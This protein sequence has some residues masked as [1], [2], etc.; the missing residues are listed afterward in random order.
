MCRAPGA[1]KLHTRKT[2]PARCGC[3]SSR[4]FFPR[5]PLSITRCSCRHRAGPAGFSAA[6]RRLFF[7]PTVHTACRNRHC[8]EP[9]CPSRRSATARSCGLGHASSPP[10]SCASCGGDPAEEGW[11]IERSRGFLASA[12]TKKVK[13]NKFGYPKFFFAKNKPGKKK[14]SKNPEN[15][16]PP[17]PVFGKNPKEKEKN[18]KP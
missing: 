7:R 13:K 12:R 14:I 8:L 2:D 10:L 1:P 6:H 9:R 3:K 18:K 11:F 15:F 4:V 16:S 5:I 17:P